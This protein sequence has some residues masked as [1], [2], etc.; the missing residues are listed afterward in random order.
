[1][2]VAVAVG[3]TRQQI[4]ALEVVALLQ[5]VAQEQVLIQLHKAVSLVRR[6]GVELPFK[7]T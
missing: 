2:A 5:Q 6:N 1:V 3:K 4:G 7:I